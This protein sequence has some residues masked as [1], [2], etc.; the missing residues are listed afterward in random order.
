MSGP[1]ACR[2]RWTAGRQ[3]DVLARASVRRGADAHACA[4]AVLLP[5]LRRWARKSRGA[6]ARRFGMAT[7]ADPERIRRTFAEVRAIMARRV[8]NSLGTAS[9]PCVSSGVVA[10]AVT[11]PST[12]SR[13]ICT[14]TCSSLSM[15]SACCETT[16]R[17]SNPKSAIAAGGLSYGVHVVVTAARWAQ[18]HPAARPDGLADR[19][20]SG[21]PLDSE[22]S[23]RDAE[24]VPPTGPA[25]GSPRRL[26]LLI[27]VPGLGPNE[28][29]ADLVEPSRHS[30]P[31]TS[32]RRCRSCPPVWTWSRCAS[33][34]SAPGPICLGGRTD[35]RRRIRPRAS[36]ARLHRPAAPAGVRRRRARQ[37]LAAHDAR[38]GAGRR[39]DSRGGQ[40]CRRRLSPHDARPRARLAPR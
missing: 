15:A 27:A 24:L 17:N 22:M 4:G 18:I 16:S 11:R 6:S 5:R 26:H 36:T 32:A 39:L 30:T 19:V 38:V 2:R 14:A 1:A 7:R 28:G 8:T 34:S 40:A 21:D 31:T 3:V 35:R 10:T 29:T 9:N 12:G 23:R 13:S 25:G 37:D 33:T 20:A